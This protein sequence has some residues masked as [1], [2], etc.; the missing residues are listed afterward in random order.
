MLNWF[1]K[2]API[3]EKFRFL[4]TVQAGLSAIG[5]A[6][7]WYAGGLSWLTGI[8]AAGFAMTVAMLLYASRQ[9]CTPYVNTVLR[10][11]A[12]AAGDTD[13]PILY[14][15][16]A[17]CVGRMTAAMSAFKANI[18][19]VQQARTAQERIVQSISLGLTNLA[20]NNLSYTIDEPFPGEADSLRRNFNAAMASSKDNAEQV[21]QARAVQ[22]RIVQSIS[23]GL[24]KLA[25]ND[26]VYRIDE[27]FPGEADSLRRNFNEALSAIAETI[28]AVNAGADSVS[29][30]ASEI[31]AASDDLALRNEQQAASLEETAAAMNEVTGLVKATAESASEVQQSIG[32]AQREAT[33]GGNV[34]RRAIAAM[35]AI[36]R[37]SQEITQIID[38]IDGISFQT[39]LLA[40]NAGVEAARAGDAGKGFAVVANEVRALA[41]R[42][43]ASAKD[44]KGLITTSSAQVDEGV[45]LV[46]ET[47]T[48]LEKIVTRVGEA[49]TLVNEIAASAENQAAN[50]VQINS[51]VGEM[52]RMTQQ[53]AAMVEQSTAAARSLAEEASE[54]TKMVSRFRTGGESFAAV[55]PL[56]HQPTRSRKRAPQAVSGNLALKRQDDEDWSEF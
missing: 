30:G 32:Q 27:P 26:L 11:E 17:D 20:E 46:G 31:R 49:S 4:V 19:E 37:S 39:N 36:E 52:D 15:D 23:L 48:V 25:E 16:H 45:A 10:M 14:T 54:L 8:A 41:Q 33:D 3:R 24:A 29:T 55:V 12:L 13:S 40:L 2:V 35:G 43:A 18:V 42:A 53:N 51:A 5:V 47:G 7:T 1:Y 34:V 50:L 21:Q 44:I 9:I 56:A 6:T 22:E 28:K 38:V